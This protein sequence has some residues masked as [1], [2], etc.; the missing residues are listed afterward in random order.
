LL[1]VNRGKGKEMRSKKRE[2]GHNFFPLLP[3]I[4]AINESQLLEMK[5]NGT[6]DDVLGDSLQIR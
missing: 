4:M 2:Y 3:T 6:A 1:K 5:S